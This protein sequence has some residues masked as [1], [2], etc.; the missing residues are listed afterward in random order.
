VSSNLG[1]TDTT[2]SAYVPETTPCQTTTWTSVSSTTCLGSSGGAASDVIWLSFA[3]NSITRAFTFDPPVVTSIRSPSFNYAASS[4]P[5][6]LSITGLNFFHVDKTP[7][8]WFASG[9][10]TTTAW[11]SATSVELTATRGQ[12]RPDISLRVNSLLGTFFDAVTFDC[13][14]MSDINPGYR[15]APISVAQSFT[16]AGFNFN[17]V[18][19]SPSEPHK[20]LCFH[21]LLPAE[22]ARATLVLG[23]WLH[24]SLRARWHALL[25]E[26]DRT[27]AANATV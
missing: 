25:G 20:P 5:Y 13:P 1:T 23:A 16:V 6:L 17:A 26:R 11:T 22:H 10:G 21:A 4:T 8:V 19:S 24:S 18:D 2:P 9:L 12:G 3:T 7:S 14:V 15:N 27:E